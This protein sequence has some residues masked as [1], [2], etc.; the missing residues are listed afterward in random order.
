MRLYAIISLSL[1]VV[2]LVGIVILGVIA[3][4]TYKRMKG[5]IIEL[6]ATVDKY[7]KMIYGDGGLKEQS[8][9]RN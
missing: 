1:S 5:R 7:E 2:V 3:F 4:R 6:Q 8:K 9:R